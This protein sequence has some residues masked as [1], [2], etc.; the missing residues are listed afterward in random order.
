LRRKYFPITNVEVGEFTIPLIEVQD[1]ALQTDAAD[2]NIEEVG[3][4]EPEDPLHDQQED[5]EEEE[6]DPGDHAVATT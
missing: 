3:D 5:N 2:P 6:E 1:H 4:G